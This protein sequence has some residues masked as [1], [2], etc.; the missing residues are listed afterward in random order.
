[1]KLLDKWSQNIDIHH[2]LTPGGFNWMHSD[3]QDVV[4]KDVTELQFVSLY[5]HIICGMIEAG[6]HKNLELSSQKLFDEFLI[7]FDYFKKYRP[8]I[9]TQTDEYKNWKVYINSFYAKL[10]HLTGNKY[11]FQGYLTQ[12]LYNYYNDLL[13]NN[14]NKILYIDT[15]QLYFTDTIDLLDF[16]IPHTTDFVPYIMFSKKKQYVMLKDEIIAR[17]YHKDAQSAKDRLRVFARQDK[18][19]KLFT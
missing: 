11:N 19:E 3:I 15:D 13:E 9:K 4:L 1:M 6:L 7:R 16:N 14:K 5:P 17:G 18:L 12:Y 10:Y 2:I 8:A